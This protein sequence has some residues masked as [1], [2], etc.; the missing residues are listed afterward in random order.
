LNFI[1]QLTNCIFAA[2]KFERNM[3]IIGKIREKSGL[4][5]FVVGLGLILFIIPFDSLLGGLGGNGEQPIGQIHGEDIYESEYSKYTERNQSG[6][7]NPEQKLSDEYQN[8][9]QMMS[10][11]VYVIESG[12]VG[13]QSSP[14]EFK[15]VMIYGKGTPSNMRQNRAFGVPDGRDQNGQE[16]FK[17]SQ[18]SLKSWYEG[19]VAQKNGATADVKANLD[20]TLNS[21]R[22]D[23]ERGRIKD[24]YN[25]MVQYASVASG[26][27][28]I[29]EFKAKNTKRTLTFV[30]G[31]YNN[32]PD[33]LVTVTDADLK[34]KFEKEKN[35]AKWK[36]EFD[37]KSFDYVVF[38][39][40]P[41]E[42]DMANINASLELLKESFATVSN[43]TVFIDKNSDVKATGQRQHM[44]EAL[45]LKYDPL[46][47]IYPA[48]M[49]AAIEQGKQG[50]VVGP[51]DLTFNSISGEGVYSTIAKITKAEVTTDDEF[52]Q[53]VLSLSDSISYD[54]KAKA[55]SLVEVIKA[56]PARFT[57]I[58]IEL[59]PSQ[60]GPDGLQGK[61]I[62]KEEGGDAP[63]EINDFVI[64]A[65]VSDIAVIKT[66]FGYH[67]VKKTQDNLESR[68]VAFISKEIK[69]SKQTIVAAK[70]KGIDY[71]KVVGARGF[72]TAAAEYD[73]EV[74]KSP[75][76]IIA[77]P[78]IDQSL[79][80]IK[81]FADWAFNPETVKGSISEPHLEKNQVMVAQ[82]TG[83]SGEGAPSFEGIKE[84]LRAVVLKEKKIEYL[85]AQAGDANSLEAVLTSWLGISDST[86]V[87]Q[88][89]LTLASSSFK[90]AP[91]DPIAVATA[92][93]ASEGTVTKIKGEEGAYFV[94]VK[95]EEAAVL[96]AELTEAQRQAT[97]KIQLAMGPGY[98]SFALLKAAD[99]KDWRMKSQILMEANKSK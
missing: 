83:V 25:A 33:S 95:N 99:V 8:F 13:L 73:V 50:D 7:T 30:Y 42:K 24:K 38:D 15:E 89:E 5:I 36:Q 23:F 34:A 81:L 59:N 62:A 44:L 64:G 21:I 37:S 98:T 97:Q 75:S 27:D 78:I 80:Y 77:Y 90:G 94:L 14:A 92:F 79:G 65:A 76:M 60:F 45:P 4:L 66:S 55:D 53:I 19:L 3:A 35:L 96:P 41:S 84:Q 57:T 28:A 93:T 31:N 1:Y 46:N 47:T 6:A 68:N 12:L 86:G 9:R 18:D 71:R 52:K 2:L 11:S 29:K 87:T 58:G 63:V 49:T 40:S 88:D 39:I 22:G 48:A 74:L 56:N 26:K 43:D 91:A 51:Y 17:F 67:I 82:V 32:V 20:R 72:E 61:G 70:T 10:D 16:K 54:V 69:A 85:L